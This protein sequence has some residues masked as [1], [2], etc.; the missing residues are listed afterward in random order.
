MIIV[1]EDRQPDSDAS[2][3]DRLRGLGVQW[4]DGEVHTAMVRVTDLLGGGAAAHGQAR[5]LLD[6]LA[7][8]ST[9]VR[10]LTAYLGKLTDEQLVALVDPARAP[11]PSKPLGCESCRRGWLDEDAEGRPV[12]C[13]TCKPHVVAA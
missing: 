9:P 6:R 8:R 2:T 4:S 12:P 1:P 13:P 11:Q 10:S 3:A 5:A 7:G